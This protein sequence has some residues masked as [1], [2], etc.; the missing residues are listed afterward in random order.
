[1]AEFTNRWFSRNAA[2]CF[3]EVLTTYMTRDRLAIRYL[4]IGAYE[5]RSTLWMMEN[6]L[7]GYND[8]ATIIDPFLATDPAGEPMDQVERRCRQNLVK[9][10]SR[11]T[12]IKAKSESAL[13]AD[14]RVT[15]R[16]FDIIFIDG[17]HSPDAAKL[18][19][20]LCWPRLMVRG[21][22][23]CDDY[24]RRSR[25]VLVKTTTAVG[26]DAGLDGCLFDVLYDARQLAIRRSG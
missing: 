1:M 7:T 12:I 15:D 21:V 9:Y 10:G 19:V 5:G 24:K 6:V 25:G 14:E 2:R 4:E 8:T 11:V 17:D 22:M 16:M 26:I 18:D 3:R 20:E 23:I 13:C